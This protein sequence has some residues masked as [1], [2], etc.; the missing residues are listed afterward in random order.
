MNPRLIAI[1][2][3]LSGAVFPLGDGDFTLGRA[4]PND[5]VVPDRAVSRRH[6]MIRKDGDRFKLIDL[7]S[8]NGC[9][10][11]NVPAREHE[12]NHS[13]RIGI[14]DSHFV[15][16][17]SDD[18][19]QGE[20]SETVQLDDS[21]FLSGQTVQLQPQD[22]A[23]LHPERLL[24]GGTPSGRQAR[25]LEALLKV[26]QAL[27]SSHDVATLA[28]G[29]LD[30][31]L[32]LVPA[33]RGAVLVAEESGEVRPV[34]G[35]RRGVETGLSV[36]VSRT[37]LRDVLASKKALM[38][39][40]VTQDRR[41]AQTESMAAWPVTALI[42]API[43]CRERSTGIIYVAASNL[44]RPFE[45][46]DLQLVAGLASVSAPTLES[47]RQVE[48]L[49][50]ENRRLHE[51]IEIEHRM[52]GN[53]PAM[54]Q[55]YR[56][57]ERVARTSANVLITGESG[58]GKEL[59]ARALHAQGPRAS[60]RFVALNSAAIAEYLLESELFGHERGAFTG[61]I[62][63]KKGLLEVANGGTLFLDEIGDMPLSLQPK[64]LRV[65]QDRKF[66]RV[67]GTDTLSVDI[68]IIAATHRNLEEA[69]EAGSFRQ[70]L[71]FRL[72]VLSV[73]IPPLRERREDVIPL[74]R[75]FLNRH[76]RLEKR[77]D[78]T[79]SP[80]AE[81]CLLEYDW[82]G[83]VRELESVIQNAVVLT[84]GNVIQP[85]DLSEDVRDCGDKPGSRGLF[86]ETVREARKQAILKAFKQ[87]GG[88]YTETARLLGLHVN[89]LHR[90][91]R[92]LNLKGQ[93]RP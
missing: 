26:C 21:Q 45:D 23:I 60:G 11:N 49:Q 37:L 64:L 65:V 5:V 73:H 9:F 81:A 34:Y 70:D 93:L 18:K 51:E 80:E 25:D 86:H 29:L 77:R 35:C 10:V 32:D 16:L 72:N 13:D 50:E 87:A 54:E 88:N 58:T 89:Y 27:D 61:A 12:L 90:L 75:Y 84:S 74:A 3:P 82:P 44:V 83:N 24:T 92:S 7:R 6:C 1:S 78:V 33:D 47:A 30:V 91:I 59:V 79:L 62:T 67:G 42:V 36:P 63:D 66:E 68:R 69:S 52:V 71:Y 41:I 40:N 15:F 19:G 31:I 46:A 76:S 55:V 38:C 57:I 20:Y 28:R 85:A 48:R 39:S 2:G 56:F 22:A 8:R 43:V 4:Q 14:G 17:I 53:S